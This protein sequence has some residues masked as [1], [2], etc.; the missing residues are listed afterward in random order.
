MSIVGLVGEQEAERCVIHYS[1]RYQEL[2]AAEILSKTEPGRVYRLKDVE[3]EI[4][5][6]LPGPWFSKLFN[7]RAFSRL[8]RDS[9]LRVDIRTTS[10]ADGPPGRREEDVMESLC[11]VRANAD[12]P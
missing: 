6:L 4:L 7:C 10:A 8:A 1:H 2:V 11:Q 12:L 9:Y 5:P 3:L